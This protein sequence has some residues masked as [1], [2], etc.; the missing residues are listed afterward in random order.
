MKLLLLI[1]ATAWTCF[2][3][4][5][6]TFVRSNATELPDREMQLL[7]SLICR[8]H[9][10]GSGCNACPPEMPAGGSWDVLAAYKGHFLSP[11]SEDILLS[12]SGCEPHARGWG[13]SYLFTRHE[14]TWRR[15]WYAAGFIA[16]DCRQLSGS[17]GRDRLICGSSDGGQGD[18][19]NTLYLLDPGM[20]PKANFFLGRYFFSLEDTTGT[21]GDHSNG[22]QSGSIERVEFTTPADGRVHIVVFSRRGL[23][24]VPSP[25]MQKLCGGDGK[26]KIATVP[27]RYEFVFNGSAVTPAPNNP[28]IKDHA[29]IAPRTS[30]S[31]QK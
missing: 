29:A 1:F 10:R 3:R 30:Y 20:D 8:G 21:C 25:V 2:G 27:A 7:L 31:I 4:D 24:V 15:V 18:F 12:G 14:S 26:L 9:E 13:G 11:A 22:I 17:G 16:W 28:P 6:T 19:E 23:A 5:P